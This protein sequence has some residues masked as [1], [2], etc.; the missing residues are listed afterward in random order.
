[1]SNYQYTTDI[2]DDVLE[3]AGEPLTSDSDYYTQALTYINRAY[4]AIFKGGDE[5]APDVHQE[6]WWLRKSS[7][8][9]LNLEPRK[10]G[11]AAVT[12]NST[13]VTL[14]ATVADSLAN[15]FIRFDGNPDMFR[16]LAHT[17]GTSAVTLDGIFTGATDAAVAYN[18]YKLEYA[19]ASDVLYL[20]SPMRVYQDNQSSIRGMELAELEVAWPLMRLSG[21]VPEGFSMVGEQTVRFSHYGRNDSGAYIRVEYDYLQRP[22][23]LTASVNEEPIIPRH[24]RK[25]LAD[26]ALYFIYLSKN[27]NRADGTLIMVNNQLKAMERDHKHRIEIQSKRVGTILPRLSGSPRRNRGPLRTENGHIIG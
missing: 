24:Y 7:P 9:I 14:S 3:R 8:G 19:L 27:D 26:A 4:Q 6:W 10:T 2:R 22:D 25:V 23:D 12:N 21:G 11:T 15:W 17:A 18:V 20:M 5:L 1:M 16:V 13:G